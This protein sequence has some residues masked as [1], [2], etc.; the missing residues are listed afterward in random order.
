[1]DIKCGHCGLFCKPVDEYTNFGNSEMME[2][3]DPI[4]ICAK[5]SQELEDDLVKKIKKPAC[6]YIPWRYSE[7]HKRAV[8]RLGMV[9]AGPKGAAWCQAFWPDSVPDD[10]EIWYEKGEK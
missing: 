3:P 1:M 9:L 8:K 5:C 4:L 6:P 10:Y 7:A 2:P